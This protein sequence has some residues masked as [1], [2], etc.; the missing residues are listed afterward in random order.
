VND[1]VDVA[2]AAGAHGVQLTSRSLP[3]ADAR[4]V[5][6]NRI[7]ASVH[8]LD[9]AIAAVAAGA[10]WVVAGH[11]FATPSHPG[12]PGRGIGLLRAIAA[13]VP[14]VIA[15]GG[16]TPARAALVAAAGGAGVAAIRGIW[17]APDPGGAAA[18]YL[19]SYDAGAVGR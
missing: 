10:D 11:L 19:S 2:A 7:G 4:A 17:D 3:P 1:R 8:S 6:P 13:V 18:D 9:E 12:A 5:G 15:I 14:R 16:L